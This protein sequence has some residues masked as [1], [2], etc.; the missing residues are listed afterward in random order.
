V[1][2]AIGAAAIS[3]I[4]VIA[5][6]PSSV[7]GGMPRAVLGLLIAAAVIAVPALQMQRARTLPPIHDIST[8]TQNPPQ[9]EAIL[10]LRA[11]AP[12]STEY[13]GEEIAEQQHAAYSDIQPEFFSATPET[14]FDAAMA[15]A[16]EM[17]W[18]VVAN[19]KNRGRIEATATTFWFGFKD[20]VVIRIAPHE[21]G[22]EVNMR[23]LSRVGRSDVGANAERIRDFMQ[24]LIERL[25]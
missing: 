20:D 2:G 5:T 12:N 9:F 19:D 4:G 24:R 18:D 3:L 6:R 17:G 16:R 14:T 22:S 8:D 25:R 21:V 1:Y 15:V 11:N 7:K 10:P 23:S 13:A